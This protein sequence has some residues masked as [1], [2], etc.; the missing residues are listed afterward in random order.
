MSHVRAD[1]MQLPIEPTDSNI[2][3]TSVMEIWMFASIDPVHNVGVCIPDPSPLSYLP[4]HKQLT[5][6]FG[7]WVQV[8]RYVGTAMVKKG[9]P[10]QCVISATGVEREDALERLIP[11]NRDEWGSGT[12][13]VTLD[14]C[15]ANYSPIDVS[16]PL[17]SWGQGGGQIT[18]RF[19]VIKR[20]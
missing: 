14:C 15:Y 13:E 17:T 5:D 1:Q 18:A 3:P 12:A 19:I 4:L 20:C 11:G 16:I 2:L 8:N 6:P 7:P 9:I 10:Q